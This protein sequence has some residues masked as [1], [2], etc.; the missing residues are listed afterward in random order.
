MQS[1]MCVAISD[2]LRFSS[3]YSAYKNLLRTRPLTT[4]CITTGFLFA[5]GDILAQTQFSHTD[6]NSKPPF[7]FN[8]TLR[9]TI[10]GSIIFAPIGDRWYKTLAKIKAPRSISNSKTDTLARVMADQLGFAPFLG[11]PLYYSAMTFLEMRPN[12]AKEAIERVE[13]NWWSTLKVNW[14]VWPVFQLFNFGLVPVQFHLLTVN[15]ISIGWNCYISMLNARHGKIAGVP[16]EEE[17]VMM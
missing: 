17:Q 5:T 9:A 1:Y 6:D 13:N 12:P 4:N 7:D 11:V 15:V 2:L 3:M 10:Y 8:R 16:L 14:C